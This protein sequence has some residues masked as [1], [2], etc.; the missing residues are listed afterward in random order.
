MVSVPS[1]G[2][3]SEPIR[4]SDEFEN[5]DEE[6]PKP[7]GTSF[8]QFR[9]KV[10][11]APSPVVNW[12]RRHSDDRPSTKRA[13][14]IRKITHV[15]GNVTRWLRLKKDLEEKDDLSASSANF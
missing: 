14:S 8:K 5:E 15:G 1:P 13:P 12:S 3:V 4:E 6:A 10:E 7:R 9:P 2:D 11:A